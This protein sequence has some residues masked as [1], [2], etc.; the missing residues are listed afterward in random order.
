MAW[1]INIGIIIAITQLFSYFFSQKSDPREPIL[2]SPKIPII[3]HVLGLQKHGNMYMQKLMLVESAQKF[4]C[5][6][7]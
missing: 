6:R 1:G 3:G 7:F 5:H 2:L 4:D